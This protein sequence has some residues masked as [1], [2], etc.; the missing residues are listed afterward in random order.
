MSGGVSIE[1]DPRVW[2]LSTEMRTQHTGGFRQQRWCE[3]FLDRGYSVRSFCMTGIVSVAVD[4]FRTRDELRRLRALWIEAAPA[5]PGHRAGPLIE[6][7]R[8]IKH[9]FLLDLFYPCVWLLA[10]SL[11]IN[12]R[13]DRQR[14]LLLCSSPPFSPAIA[15][16]FAKTLFGNRVVFALDMRDYWSLHGV[17]AKFRAHKMAIERA[18]M[19]RVD[20][21]TTIGDSMAGEFQ[22]VFGVPTK[23]VYNVATHVGASVAEPIDWSALNPLIREDSTKIVYTGSLPRGYYDLDALVGGIRQAVGEAREPWRLQ[24][25]FV[26]NCWEL[27][28]RVAGFP[29]LTNKLVFTGQIDQP[30]AASVQQGAD[31]LLFLGLNMPENMGHVSMKIFEYLRSR[32]PILPLFIREKSDVGTLIA[33]YCGSC[34]AYSDSNA[35]SSALIRCNREGVGWLPTPQSL[36]VESELLRSYEDIAV[37]LIERLEGRC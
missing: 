3:Y 2:I 6:C 20:M 22:R 27:K 28:V 9:V 19:R 17:R 23:A 18:V 33:R 11:C 10:L 1:G 4:D 35:I 32:V 24:F 15:S 34:V 31:C 14:V 30:R 25:I 5:R 12:L 29:E 16:A 37:G 36:D 8:V 26:G 21:L 13:R 7:A